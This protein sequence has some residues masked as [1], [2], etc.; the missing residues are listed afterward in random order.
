MLKTIKT[1]KD[2]G[3]AEQVQGLTVDAEKD[4]YGLWHYEVNGTKWVA[5][6]YAFEEDEE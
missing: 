5:S 6:D 4:E 1:G 2:I 3:I